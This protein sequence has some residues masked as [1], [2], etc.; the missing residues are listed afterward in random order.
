MELS[1]WLKMDPSYRP[2]PVWGGDKYS[3][4]VDKLSKEL[5]KYFETTVLYGT[6]QPV[7]KEKE[8]EIGGNKCHLCGAEVLHASDNST[9]LKKK[10][11]HEKHMVYQCGTQIL[12]TTKSKYIDASSPY[13]VDN[14]APERHIHAECI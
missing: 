7:I 14:P 13:V 3:E 10:V 8:M 5:R 6:T 1:D 12:E 2:Q 11:V 9:Y 4:Y